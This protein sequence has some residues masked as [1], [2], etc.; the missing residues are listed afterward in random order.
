MSLL[1]GFVLIFV[2]TMLAAYNRRLARI[3]TRNRVEEKLEFG[4][5]TVR[6]NIAIVG[7]TFVFGGL[8]F[9]YLS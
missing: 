8:L 2:G 7:G 5:S 9:I 1:I 3:F 6:Q 4:R